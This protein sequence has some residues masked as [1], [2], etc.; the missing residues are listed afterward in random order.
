MHRVKRAII[1]AAGVGKRMQPVTLSVPKPL[2]EVNGVRMIDTVI[3]ALHK[4]DIFE[5]YIVVGYLKEQFRVLTDLY[6]GVTLIE[7]PYYADFNNISSL[8]MARNFLE[9]AIILDGDQI[10]NNYKVLDSEFEK[11]GYNAVWTEQKTEE[12]LMQV[13]NGKVVSCSREGGEQGWQLFSISRWTEEDG[14]KL[15]KHLEEE[16]IKKQNRQIYWDDVVMFCHFDEYDLGIRPMEAGDVLEIDGYDE[17]IK[18]DKGYLTNNDI[19][20]NSFR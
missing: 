18:F 14:K 4:N 8:Y 5:I 7:N 2:V 19:V 12:W 3:E 17:L 20:T 16:F 1:M 11:S 10:I 13:E 9:D 6:S 15:R